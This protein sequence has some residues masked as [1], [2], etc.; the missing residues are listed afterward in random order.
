VGERV[1]ERVLPLMPVHLLVLVCLCVC[2]CACACVCLEE[3]ECKEE[4]G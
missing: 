3:E 4:A 1:G 2:M